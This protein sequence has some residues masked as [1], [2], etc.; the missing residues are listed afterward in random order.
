ME[1]TQEQWL[2]HCRLRRPNIPASHSSN[3]PLH[4]NEP[5]MLCNVDSGRAIRRRLYRRDIAV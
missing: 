3:Y 1:H 5:V 2:P 4:G